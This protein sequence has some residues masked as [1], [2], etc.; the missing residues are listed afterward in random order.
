[1]STKRE[2]LESKI[3]DLIKESFLE[4]GYTENVFPEKKSKRDDEGDEKEFDETKKG[5]IMKWLDSAQELHS[6]L[7]YQLWPDKDK[8]SARSLFSK[9]YRGQDDDG[10]TYEFDPSELNRLYNLRN[11]F[12]S[13][14]K[15]DESKTNKNMKKNTI[16]LNEAQL[17]KIVAESVKNVL[18][19]GEFNKTKTQELAEVLGKKIDDISHLIQLDF[20]N[21]L[22]SD[23][24]KGSD[25]YM[26]GMEVRSKMIELA[27]D[28]KSELWPYFQHYDSHYEQIGY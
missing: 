11:D 25:E 3:Y 8:D 6:V 14:A 5:L 4:N 2:L 19:E 28:L 22:Q 12:I 27:S 15:L 17:R 10:K 7:A 21:S 9:K 26:K 18:T 23:Y 24:G 1:M 20:A 16:K 13:S